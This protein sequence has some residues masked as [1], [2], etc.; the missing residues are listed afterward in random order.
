MAGLG[1]RFRDKGYFS[2]KPFIIVDDKQIIDYSFMSIDQNEYDKIIFVVLREHIYNFAIDKILK[3]KF[4]PNIDIVV[5]ES[6]TEGSVCSCLAARH[7]ID[8]DQPLVVYTLDVYFHPKFLFFED[9][10]EEMDGFILTFLSNSP[11]YSYAKV[12]PNGLVTEAKEK[13]IISRYA[14]VGIYGFKTGKLFLKYAD[15][16]IDQ[17]LKTKNEYYLSGLYNLLIRDGLKVYSK[18]VDKMHVIGT[19]EEMNFFKKNVCYR[20]SGRPIAICCDHSGFELKEKFKSILSKNNLEFIDFGCYA[21][22]D[23]DYSDYVV[24]ACNHIR[25]GFCNIAFGFCRTGQG[26]NIA[27]NKVFGI[28]GALV[29]DNYTIEHAIRHNCSNFFSVPSKYVSGET[30][31]EMLKTVMSQSFDGGRHSLRLQKIEAYESSKY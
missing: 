1:K 10:K 28:R 26:V 6:L 20:K 30:L 21:D 8:N 29:F 9:Y 31:E 18:P 24:Q 13:E 16:M 23:C 4:G 22:Q 7:L 19:P 2:P 17:R 5:V 3:S 14:I 11:N 25:E 12:E 27:A 15:Q